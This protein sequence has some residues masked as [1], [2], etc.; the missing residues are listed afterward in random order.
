LVLDH[1]GGA[2]L[3]RRATPDLRPGVP[4]FLARP[5]CGGALDAACDAAGPGP[6]PQARGA[7]EPAPYRR[8]LLAAQG[9]APGGAAPRARGT[10]YLLL[11]GSAA[12][13]GLRHDERGRACR[14][15]ED[16]RRASAAAA[17]GAHSAPGARS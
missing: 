9:K 7:A 6:R 16:D 8:A 14:S 5:A 11:A 2:S 17:D 4:H 12:A 15:E 10:P 1:V 13:H 3:A